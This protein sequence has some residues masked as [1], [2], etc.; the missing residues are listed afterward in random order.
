MKKLLVIAASLCVAALVGCAGTQFTWDQA[1]QLRNG[2][3][4]QEAT[5][6]MGA[7]TTVRAQGDRQTW[8]WVW[9]NSFTGTQ[10]VSAV[11]Q[12]GTLVEAPKIPDSFK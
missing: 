11:F 2:M 5:A 9:V 1:R 6:V 4:E 12:N 8:V 3:T 10:T 7:P